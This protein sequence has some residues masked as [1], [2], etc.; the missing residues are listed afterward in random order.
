MVDVNLMPV[1]Q[2]RGIWRGCIVQTLALWA[3]GGCKPNP[4]QMTAAFVGEFNGVR[5]AVPATSLGRG[6][7]NVAEWE[8]ALM[9]L[10]YALDSEVWLGQKMGD[11]RLHLRM[12]SRLVV[13]ALN[14]RLQMRAKHL[15]A[16]AL[17]A[18]QLL[19]QARQRYAVVEVSWV[20]RSQNADADALT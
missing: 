11:T 10:R 12:D 13:G 18:K 9:A 3:D 5:F 20:P 17:A 7:N 1:L 8:A 14:G 16:Y 15:R 19:S 4:G 6:T 2:N